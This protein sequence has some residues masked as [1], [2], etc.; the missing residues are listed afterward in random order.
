MSLILEPELYTAC[1]KAYTDVPSGSTIY[2]TLTYERKRE[3]FK[4]EEEEERC[5]IKTALDND[6]E[7]RGCRRE[8][9]RSEKAEAKGIKVVVEEGQEEDCERA[10]KRER[11]REREGEGEGEG[12][13]DFEKRSRGLRRALLFDSGRAAAENTNGRIMKMTPCDA[14]ATLARRDSFE[15]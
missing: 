14:A 6:R 12:E 3:P 1:A 11:E 7:A 15:Q 9:R 10:S 5:C 4:T 13:R 2:S 8:R